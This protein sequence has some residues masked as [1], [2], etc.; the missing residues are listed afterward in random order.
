MGK[1]K[2]CFNNWVLMV[3]FESTLSNDQYIVQA[4]HLQYGPSYIICGCNLNIWNLLYLFIYPF[5]SSQPMTEKTV[6]VVHLAQVIIAMETIP[7]SQWLC[8]SRVTWHPA[9]VRPMA[10]SSPACRCHAWAVE[11]YVHPPP[12]LAMPDPGLLGLF[13]AW[14]AGAEDCTE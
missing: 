4:L 6:L 3:F 2:K 11:M 1:L 13:G 14:K 10:D 7:I 8:P 5:I 12:S 9:A